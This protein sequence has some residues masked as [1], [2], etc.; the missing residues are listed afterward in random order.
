MLNFC[1]LFWHKENFKSGSIAVVLSITKRLDKIIRNLV[2]FGCDSQSEQTW[3][4]YLVER[5]SKFSFNICKINT[6]L[7]SQEIKKQ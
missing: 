3:E 4:A 2:I 5:L 6:A 1:V 7:S